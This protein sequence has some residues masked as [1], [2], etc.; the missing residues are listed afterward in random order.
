MRRVCLFRQIGTT[1][2][3]TCTLTLSDWILNPARLPIPPG[4]HNASGENRTLTL[5]ERPLRPSRLPLRHTGKEGSGAIRT[6]N[7]LVLSQTP[8][9][10]GLQGLKLLGVWELQ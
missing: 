4:R 3:E 1:G 7:I 6:H 9:P 10:V 8:L 2:R 5:S